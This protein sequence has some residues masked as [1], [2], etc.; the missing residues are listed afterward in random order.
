MPKKKEAIPLSPDTS[1]IYYQRLLDMPRE[2]L[3]ELYQMHALLLASDLTDV[4]VM[5]GDEQVLLAYGTA[6]QGGRTM[7]PIGMLVW[8]ETEPGE[9]WTQMGYVCPSHRKSGVYRKLWEEML[10]IAVDDGSVVDIVGGTAYDNKVM[11]KV[12]VKMGRV[13]SSI[14][15]KYKVK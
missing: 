13:P 6:V 5:E 7:H 9:W 12:M 4:L 2:E 15:Y 1:V 10:H 14:I 11:Q 3:A 8:R